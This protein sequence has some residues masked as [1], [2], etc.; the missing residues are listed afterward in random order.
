MSALVAIVAAV[1]SAADGGTCSDSDVQ[2]RRREVSDLAD[3]FS[4]ANAKAESADDVVKMSA[5]VEQQNAAGARLEAAERKHEDCLRSVLPMAGECPTDAELAAQQDRIDDTK[6]FG[7]RNV[8]DSRLHSMQRA[9]QACEK[10]ERDRQIAEQNAANEAREKAEGAEDDAALADPKRRDIILS[11][12][13]CFVEG[14]RDQAK[15]EIAKERDAAK[16]GGVV[17]KRVLYRE[18]HR[19]AEA[20]KE[21]KKYLAGIIGKRLSCKD[22]RVTN[23]GDKSCAHRSDDKLCAGY[24]VHQRIADSYTSAFVASIEDHE[25]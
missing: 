7:M 18:G 17:D 15:A 2:Q 10:K 11:T 6:S 14:Y 9:R 21:L 22:P 8:E 19:A 4:K 3:K 23:I 16:Y 1:L 12:A 5:I 13:A 25:E 24:E 20:D